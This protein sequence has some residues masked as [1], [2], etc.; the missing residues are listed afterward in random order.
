[1]RRGEGAN[2]DTKKS[3][4]A[5]LP[6]VLLPLSV[7]P[8]QVGVVQVRVKVVSAN[9]TEGNALTFQLRCILRVKIVESVVAIDGSR[10][11]FARNTIEWDLG[12]MGATEVSALEVTAQP[13][14]L[15]NTIVLPGSHVEWPGCQEAHRHDRRENPEGSW[16]ARGGAPSNPR[17][18]AGGDSGA[19]IANTAPSWL[20]LRLDNQGNQANQVSGPESPHGAQAE[21]VVV[22]G[23]SP[24]RT[25]REQENGDDVTARPA[26][27]RRLH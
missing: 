9:L 24:K 7:A 21:R 13:A 11:W 20:R 2:L 8:N 15:A 22:E 19:R 1:M 14:A 6:G 23:G 17:H 27:R 3:E 16:S 10:R 12:V 18:D 4:M 26:Q 25:R 5:H